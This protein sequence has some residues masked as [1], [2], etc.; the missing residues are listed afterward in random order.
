MSAI[1]ILLGAA[2]VIFGFLMLGDD[3]IAALI[4]VALGGCVAWGGVD[5]HHTTQALRATQQQVITVEND[6][7]AQIKELKAQSTEYQEAAMELSIE[8]QALQLQQDECVVKQKVSQGTLSDI[9]E[10]LEN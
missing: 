6:Y 1:I 2:L 4:A 5:Y 10:I 7:K 9:K 3:F 8:N